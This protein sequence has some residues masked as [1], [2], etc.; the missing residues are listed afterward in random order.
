MALIFVS[1]S[2]ADATFVKD[3]VAK[4]K[5]KYPKHDIWYD[6][7]LSGGVDWWKRIEANIQNCQIFL[8]LISN[9]ALESEYCQKELRLALSFTDKLLVPVVVRP[10][11]ELSRFPE[12]LRYFVADRQR[13]NLEHGFENKEEVRKLW[14]T[15]DEELKKVNPLDVWISRF[16]DLEYKALWVSVILSSLAFVLYFWLIP[17]VQ[18]IITPL[19]FSK[20]H[21]VVS[22]VEWQPFVEENAASFQDI[23]VVLVPAGCLE[24][25]NDSEATNF[26]EFGVPSGGE[27]C[28][29]SPFWIST[30]E[31]SNQQVLLPD[32]LSGLEADHPHTN[33][34]WD[35]AVSA[36]Q[37]R[38]MRLPTEA[39]WEYAARGPN[40]VLYLSNGGLPVM[41]PDVMLNVDQGTDNV[42]WVGA[43]FMAG[44]VLEW[45]SSL[46]YAYPYDSN[47]GRQLP[48][49]TG[50]ERF[51]VRGG[52]WGPIAQNF[53]R[54]ASRYVRR[55]F[56]T[57]TDLGFRCV[58]DYQSDR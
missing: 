50:N 33:I 32:S 19:G 39:E 35:D 3:F 26:M 25:G 17:V 4:L 21:P 10:K 34:T 38:G 13:I 18:R 51:V 48:Y 6:N 45:T 49:M 41:N 40:G 24:L 36:C 43:Y 28:F 15:I 42:S 9:D 57:G 55:P 44:N 7:E 29:D 27:Y 52:N 1:Y 8:F 22:N 47:D 56:E 20:Y 53:V 2:K 5:S 23:D 54:L 46:A 16:K 31:I 58:R 37:R 12:E 14:K 11:W 30:Y